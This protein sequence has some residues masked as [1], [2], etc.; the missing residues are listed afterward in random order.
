MEVPPMK[1]STVFRMVCL[2]ASIT[3]SVHAGQAGRA[4]EA[5]MPTVMIDPGSGHAAWVDQSLAVGASGRA[6]EETFNQSEAAIINDLL[7]EIP[8]GGCVHADYSPPNFVFAPAR[9]TI[10]DAIRTADV[11]IRGRITGKSLGF[12]AGIPG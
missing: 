11:I 9:D 5:D 12:H 1:S 6:N 2:L 8:E 7:Q 3:A 10:E 4:D